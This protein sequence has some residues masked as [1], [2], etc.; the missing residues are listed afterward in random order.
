MWM[1]PSRLFAAFVTVVV[2]VLSLRSA[3]SPYPPGTSVAPFAEW[4][5]AVSLDNGEARAVMVPAAGGRIL[6]YSLHSENLLYLD[7]ALHGKT[8]KS[9][10]GAWAHGGYQADIGP[11]LRGMPDHPGLWWG[12]YSWHIRG[13]YSVRVSSPN[14]PDT[15]VQLIK[16]VTMD[17]DT[18]D[19]GIVQT[20]RN[21]SR[22]PVKYCVW[23]RTLC[24]NTGFAIVPL[25]RRSRFANGWALRVKD[26]AGRWQYDGDAPAP[27]EVEVIRDHLVVR[28]QGPAT[29]VGL[30]SDAGWVA[31][32]RG[33]LMLVKYFPF[34]PGGNYSDGGCSVEIYF[35]ERVAELEPLSPEVE[36]KPGA[37]YDFPEKWML[38]ELDKVVV[39]A[40]DAQRAARRIRQSPFQ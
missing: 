3:D 13:P 14:D 6:R 32:V 26:A 24:L 4:E 39:T 11:E 1:S 16:E 21:H 17:P 7:P 15:G 31:Y 18:G 28:C 30:D 2:P 5:T 37:T 10:N 40:K 19:L 12:E 36:L 25:N 34:V 9:L 29:K 23:D 20:I 27:R 38:V 8:L 35:D 22:E 33:H